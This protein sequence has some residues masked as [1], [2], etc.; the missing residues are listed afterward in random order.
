M[1]TTKKLSFAPLSDH[2][3][4]MFFLLVTVSLRTLI[5]YQGHSGQLRVVKEVIDACDGSSLKYR[6]FIE[7]ILVRCR[8]KL[9]KILE[10]EQ[11][12]E[13]FEIALEKVVHADRALEHHKGLWM[14][15]VGRDYKTAYKQLEKAIRT[16]QYPGTERVEHIEHIHTSLAATVTKAIREGEQTVQSGLEIVKDHIRKAKRPKVFSAH[17]AHVI[18][19]VYLEVAQQSGCDEGDRSAQ[20]N[21]ASDGACQRF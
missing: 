5:S 9:E 21:A 11:G 7:D 15:R 8:H 10:Y 6:N 19:G 2:M 13:L 16:E 18:A 3:S 20:M 1:A 17:N 14:Q 12:L 4:P